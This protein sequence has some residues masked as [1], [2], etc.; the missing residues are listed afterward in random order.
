MEATQWKAMRDADNAV[1]QTVKDIRNKNRELIS[2][3][4]TDTVFG[5]K[6]QRL[7]ETITLKDGTVKES[8]FNYIPAGKYTTIRRKKGR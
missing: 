7:K 2:K 5:F 3:G 6:P 4:I 8:V 1:Y